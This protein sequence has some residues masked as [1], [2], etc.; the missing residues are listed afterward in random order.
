M[1]TGSIIAI[2]ISFYLMIVVGRKLPV[3]TVYAVFFG[4]GTVGTVLTDIIF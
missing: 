2:M 3:G 4:L 1:W